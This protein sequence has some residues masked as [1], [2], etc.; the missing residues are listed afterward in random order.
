MPDADLA[1]RLRRLENLENELIH[2]GVQ[3]IGPNAAIHQTD[4]FLLGALRRTLAQS[5]GFRDL[6][7]ARNFPCAA[8]IL[9][10]QLDTAMRVNAL[11]LIHDVENACRAV[12]NGEQFNRLKDRDRIK[13]SD[14]HLLRKLAESH[15]WAS[16]VYKDTS[17]FVHLSGR[18]FISS[19]ARA[20]DATRTVHFQIS[21]EDPRRPEEDYFEAVD[22][23]FEA[24]KLSGTLILACWMT[25]HPPNGERADTN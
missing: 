5:R 2:K 20:D 12:L 21:G 23:F 24:T 25:I 13:M 17:D 4:L 11:S 10:L 16:K 18:H 22:A 1:G 9:R 6:I 3:S 7:S 14:A 15:P 8:A 19:I